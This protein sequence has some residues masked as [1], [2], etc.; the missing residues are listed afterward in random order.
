MKGSHEKAKKF[1]IS[2]ERRFLSFLFNK[3]FSMKFP[4]VT[5]VSLWFPREKNQKSNKQSLRHLRQMDQG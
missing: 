5:P 2:L 4:A 1:K 3:S